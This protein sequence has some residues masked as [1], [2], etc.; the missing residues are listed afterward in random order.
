MFITLEP[1]GI[2][3]SHFAYEYMSKFPNHWHAK[4]HSLT[5]I[6][7]LSNC[8]AYCGQLVKIL[9]TIEPYRIFGSNIASLFI[10]IFSS[11]PSMQNG[12]EG[13]PSIILA[14]QGLLVKMIITLELHGTFKQTIAY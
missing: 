11:H 13:L 8:P 7:L 3:S 2:F 6:D 5:D 10:L 9:I 14:G 12:G 1:H 4:H